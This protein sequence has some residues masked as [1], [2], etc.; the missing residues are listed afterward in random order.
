MVSYIEEI[1]NQ[2][3]VIHYAGT[4]EAKLHTTLQL[5]AAIITYDLS[6]ITCPQCLDIIVQFHT[7]N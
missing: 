5:R 7:H 1:Y 3:Q 2:G 4:V 6:Y